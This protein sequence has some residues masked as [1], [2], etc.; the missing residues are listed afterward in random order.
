MNVSPGAIGAGAAVAVGL[1]VGIGVTKL[2][3]GFVE[4]NPT[5]SE[6]DRPIGQLQGATAAA[7][8][9]SFAGGMYAL[10]RGNVPLG[11]GLMGAGVGALLGTIGSA[12]V[13]NARHG[14]GVETTADN[15]LHN[16]DYNRND[17]LE[18]TDRGFFKPAETTRS[19]TTTHTD[20][21]GD[22]H[23]H[24]TYYS[25]DRLATRADANRDLVAT[26]DEL[27]DTIAPYD[28]DEN[29]RLK[30]PELGRFDRELGERIIG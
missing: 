1:G 4:R 17:Q 25:V 3:D 15:V 23:S 27:I 10:F 8:F 18:M 6:A 14:V 19:D 29:G 28:G 12:A 11:A 20:S 26:R 21:D 13:T 9:A 30:G 24:T 5:G 16:Y 7:G 22:S 2:A